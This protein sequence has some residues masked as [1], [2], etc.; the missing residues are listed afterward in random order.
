MNKKILKI[1]LII[2]LI[3]CLGGVGF[4]VY[5]IYK[6]TSPILNSESYYKDIR[7]HV[8]ESSD[9]IDF[10][11]LKELGEH[12]I[13]WIENPGTVIDY[14]IAQS[15][16]NEYYLKHLIDG[17][18][19]ENGAIFLDYENKEDFSDDVS[20]IYGHHIIM[21][22]MF[23]PL[24][25]YKEQ[26]YYKDHP[27]M[28]LYTKDTVYEVQLFAGNVVNGKDGKFPTNF[29]TPEEKEAFLQEKISKS[30]FT[31][32]TIPTKDDKILILCTCTYEYDDARYAVFGKL[33]EKR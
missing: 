7:D 18:A 16:D 15:S 17:T 12:A 22:R 14:P 33:V 8:K 11:Q 24:N 32:D 13:G 27:V 19:N 29:E 2:L 26:S 5:N 25:H 9:A 30:T 23:S 20:A 3:G 31:S 21:D 10:V 6:D 28:I 4:F 1:S